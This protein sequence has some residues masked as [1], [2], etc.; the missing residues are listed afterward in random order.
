MPLA[1]VSLEASAEPQYASFYTDKIM[2]HDLKD[3]F[4]ITD[5]QLRDH[6][7]RTPNI[8]ECGKITCRAYREKSS[9]WKNQ[10]RKCKPHT[11]YTCQICEKDSSTEPVIC[12]TCKSPGVLRISGESLLFHKKDLVEK[13]DLYTSNTYHTH[14]P[15]CNVC[16]GCLKPPNDRR[17]IISEPITCNVDTRIFRDARIVKSVKF[18]KTGCLID[19]VYPKKK[20]IFR[21]V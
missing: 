2:L 20:H 5:Q 8:Y 6:L 12:P 9:F 10:Y 1:K 16:H 4:L 11:S 18:S 17:C 14:V 21:I 3:T 7:Y 13:H 19:A 15:P